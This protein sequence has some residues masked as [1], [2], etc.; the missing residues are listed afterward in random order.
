VL[1]LILIGTAT[2]FFPPAADHSQVIPNTYLDVCTTLG[3]LLV[4]DGGSN[5]LTFTTDAADAAAYVDEGS[6]RQEDWWI[7]QIQG[8]CVD[9]LWRGDGWMNEW[10][11]RWHHKRN[12]KQM[13][14]FSHTHIDFSQLDVAK[15][16]DLV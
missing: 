7:V 10:I 5:Q 14:L 11:D 12:E 8:L 3:G 1:I 9:V 2:P 15:A 6:C 4:S 16:L 13:R